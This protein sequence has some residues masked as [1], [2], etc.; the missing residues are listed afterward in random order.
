MP[1]FCISRF[2]IPS[3]KY[4]VT[5]YNNEHCIWSL[6]PTSTQEKIHNRSHS[7]PPFTLYMYP[8]LFICWA[9]GIWN[10]AKFG[11]FG[12]IIIIL[13]VWN[14]KLWMWC[15]T[16]QPYTDGT[17]GWAAKSIPSSYHAT[18]AI[19]SAL[20]SGS[21]LFY[22]LFF[23]LYRSLLWCYQPE[24]YS[25]LLSRVDLSA[26]SLITRATNSNL[27]LRLRPKQVNSSSL[28]LEIMDISLCMAR[29]QQTCCRL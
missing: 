7:S 11:W 29:Q 3:A 2:W 16:S 22:P 4:K 18:Q 27:K 12:N 19:L 28:S 5:T 20:I 23:F 15:F 13:S 25:D 17:V 14:R 6:P 24:Q 9:L 1:R 21:S 8:V 10:A 26:S